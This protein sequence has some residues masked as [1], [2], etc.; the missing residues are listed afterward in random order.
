MLLPIFYC[1]SNFVSTLNPIDGE[2]VLF[3]PDPHT[4][5]LHISSFS[6][7]SPVCKSDSL[8]SCLSL[9]IILYM[10]LI[11]DRFGD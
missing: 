4:N 6:N 3:C 1:I 2:C 7:D 10:S 9:F 5:N 8:L 11:S